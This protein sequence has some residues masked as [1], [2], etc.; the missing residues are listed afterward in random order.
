M[1]HPVDIQ[2]NRQGSPSVS[3]EGEETTNDE[4]GDLSDMIHTMTLTHTKWSSMS[5][6]PLSRVVSNDKSLGT[7]LGAAWTNA[8]PSRVCIYWK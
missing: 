2:S 7:R 4:Q 1:S 3:D 8:A 6:V 5:F